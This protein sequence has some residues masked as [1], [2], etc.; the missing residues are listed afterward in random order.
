MERTKNGKRNLHTE[1]VASSGESMSQPEA[2][3]VG[4]EASRFRG[5]CGLRS[6]GKLKDGR[7]ACSAESDI[8]Q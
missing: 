4:S 7:T 6:P 8:L 2:L 5:L 3:V 1:A